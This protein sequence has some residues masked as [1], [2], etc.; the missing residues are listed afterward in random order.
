MSSL[1]LARKYRPRNFAEMAGQPHVVK[2]LSH[3]LANKRLHHAYL[4]TGTRGIG[5][6]TVSRIF[7]KSLNCTGEDGRGDV[8]ASPCGRCIACREI[9]ADRYVDYVELDAASN[10]SI[11]EIRDLIERASYKPAVG[12]YKVFMIDEAHQLTK[13][14]FNALLKTLE[15]PPDYL[16]FILATTDPDRMLPTVL[17]RCLQFNLRPMAPD[18]VHDHLRAVLTAEAVVFEEAAL[19]LLAHSARGSMRDALSLTDQAIAHG[20]GSLDEAGVRDMLGAS[21][22]SLARVIAAQLAQADTKGLLGSCEEIRAKGVAASSVLEEL[23][24]FL[25]LVAL[26]QATDGADP[27]AYEGAERVNEVAAA[28]DPQ[29]VQLLYSILLQGKAEL[30]LMPDDVAALTMLLLR[31]MAFAAPETFSTPRTASSA[32]LRMPP[33]ATLAVR[34]R[35]PVVTQTPT[36]VLAPSPSPGEPSSAAGPL[37]GSGMSAGLDDLWDDTVRRLAERLQLSGMLRELAW[38]SQL[39]K[40]SSGDGEGAVAWTLK[41]EHESLRG[42]GLR[43]RLESALRTHCELRVDLTVIPGLPSDSPAQREAAS[44]ARRQRE[45]ES[46][47]AADPLV[48]DLM[49]Q[50]PGAR[51]VPG[52]VRPA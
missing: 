11:D 49:A 23:T 14:A 9:D 50:F 52:S 21:G 31:F 46:A 18:V 6:T 19:K 13:D 30:S 3:A 24:Q 44:K 42:P 15:E 12:R 35:S 17:S 27:I 2:A 45:A 7:A 37:P 38:Q 5:K 4:F 1:V 16:K 41:V 48:R 32:P 36:E 28:F 20:G 29:A 33:A 10:R 25:Q 40:A 22:A 39:V 51:V 26:R 43:E 34:P 47:I 8:T